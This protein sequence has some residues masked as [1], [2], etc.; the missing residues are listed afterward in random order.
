MKKEKEKKGSRMY[1]ERK[2]ERDCVSCSDVPA[3]ATVKGVGPR[4]YIYL[5]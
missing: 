1:R 2:R 4:L 3:V 5:N